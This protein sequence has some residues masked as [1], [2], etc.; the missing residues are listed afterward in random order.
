MGVARPKPPA[1][2]MSWPVVAALSSPR[3][4]TAAA[5]LRHLARG[6]LAAEEHAAHVRVHPGEEM[7]VRGAQQ[8]LVLGGVRAAEVVHEPVDAPSVATTVSIIDW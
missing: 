1:T 4:Y 3:K 8:V 2:S 5:G 7:L 6:R